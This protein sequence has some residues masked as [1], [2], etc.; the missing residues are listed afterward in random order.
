M[1][2]LYLLL[3]GILL[4]GA[5]MYA[6]TPQAINYQG[7][8][9]D[10]SGNVLANQAVAL[11]LS[12]LTG[13]VTGTA[14]YVETHT[15]T[16]D[17]F[18]LFALHIGQGTVVSGSFSTIDWGSN[19]CYLKVEIDPAGGTTY[20]VV[21]TSQFASVPYA[22]Y[23]QS[24]GSATHGNN[25]GDMLYWN[26]TSWV[27]IPAG[28]N[29]QQ[30]IFCNGVPAWGGCASLYPITDI[31]GNGYDT[32]HIGT[33]IWLKQNLK[34]THYR[35]GD[36][37]PNVT[38]G[39]EWGNLTTGAYCNYNNDVNN[40]T[41]YGRLYNW[42]AVND[43]RNIAPTG[44][45]V[46]TDTEWTTLTNFLGTGTAGNKLKET[47]T[48]HW[49]SPNSGATNETGFTALPGGARSYDGASSFP[50]GS[51]GLWWSA[52]EEG[53]IAALYRSMCYNYSYV[54]G[55]SFING[56]GFSVR[57]IKDENI[58]GDTATVTT[59]AVI[60]IT[61]ATATSGGNVISDG[62]S[63]VTARGVCWNTAPNPTIANSFTT[64]GSG[65]GAFVSNLT[66]LTANTLYYVRAYATNSVGTAYGNEV[67]F[68]TPTLAVHYIG[69]NFGGGIIFY[70]DSTSQNMLISSTTDQGIAPWGC[71]GTLIGTSTAIGTGQTNTTAIVNGC[72]ATGIAARICNDLVLNG[73]EDWFLPS[74]DE[75]N[76]MYIQKNIIGSFTDNIYINSSEE[77]SDGAW[78][79]HFYWGLQSTNSKSYTAYVRAIRAFSTSVNLLTVTTDAVIDIT[80]ATATSGGN[81]ISDGGSSVTAR[82][83]CWNTSPNPTIANSFTNDGSGTGMFVSNLTGLTTNTL[84]YVRAYATNSVGTAYGNEVSFTTTVYPVIDIDGNGYDTVHIG[85]QIWLKQNLKTTHYRNGD[86]IPN[87]TDGT[88][89]SSLTTGAYCN[90]DNDENNSTTYGRLYNWFAVGDSRNIA[91]TGWHVPTDA[92]WTTL[93]TY[94]GGESVAGGKLKEAGYTHWQSPNTGATNETGFTALPGGYLYGDGAFHDISGFGLWWSSTENS[95]N[96]AWFRI[97]G[98]GDTHVY[99]YNDD[100][101]CGLSVRCVRDESAP[102]HYIGEN[103]GGGIIFYIDGTGQHGLISATIDQGSAQWGCYGTLIGGTSSAI[104]TGQA[105]TTAIVN[106]CGEAG[107][108]ARICD[109]LVLNGYSD[110]FLP[111]RDEL[112]QMYIQRNV[113]G[114][115]LF[116]PYWSSTEDTDN[117]AWNQN[118]TNGGTYYNGKTTIYWVRAI[119]R[120]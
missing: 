12:I 75:L 14:V 47:G 50:I 61:P 115:F 74:K 77:G 11:R 89:W 62:G 93:T 101:K 112:E 15:T 30:L 25:P 72:N 45:H 100:K 91:P 111:S 109:D 92:E 99:R 22:L 98:Y 58:Q 27:I 35:N 60:D 39:T 10:N 118:F 23:A 48:A 17:G 16:T 42:Y 53:T 117:Y 56:Y 20:Q 40:S 85:T 84:Y 3:I 113:I 33:Q 43:S 103:F 5:S 32:V 114:G 73:Y 31:D 36:P 41:T 71:M 13:S 69:E 105:N 79:Q 63:P 82:G 2:K 70:I 44:W 29:G 21:G 106:G 80:P 65:T 94:L 81:V 7:V 1:K 78:G 76:Q 68:T 90:Y 104:G 52:T 88:A 19:S 24:S 86:P 96:D 34:T 54:D 102:I 8:A 57:C 110:W 26:G 59:D 38:D 87:V 46:A 120:F 28:S 49:Q 6:Q 18:G 67:S 4:F 83:V 37:I 55:G 116:A 97:M 95:T 9:R 107:I 66:G 64:D 108:A 119:R 51:Y